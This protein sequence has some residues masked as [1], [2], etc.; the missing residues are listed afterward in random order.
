MDGGWARSRP[1]PLGPG[2]DIGE[3]S[4]VSIHAYSNKI[5]LLRIPNLAT[6]VSYLARM[7]RIASR[8]TFQSVLSLFGTV[9]RFRGEGYPLKG[10]QSEG[11]ARTT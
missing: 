10:G 8:I 3:G 5:W 2:P 4:E 1:R 11:F 9:F 7:K 6:M